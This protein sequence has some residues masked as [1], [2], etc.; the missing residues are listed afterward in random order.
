MNLKK[1]WVWLVFGYV[2]VSYFGQ[3]MLSTALLAMIAAVLTFKYLED[4]DSRTAVVGAAMGG[5]D[6]DE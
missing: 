6:Y 5:D 2:L 1:W 3:S 4:R